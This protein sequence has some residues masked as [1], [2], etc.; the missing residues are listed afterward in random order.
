MMTQSKQC[1]KCGGK[2]KVIKDPCA[3]C[4]GAG[5]IRISKTLNVDIPAG[6]DNGQAVR[7]TGEGDVGSNGGSKG[8]LIVNVTVKKDSFFTRDGFDAHCD[9]P[10]TYTQAVLGDKITIP[11]I[12]GKVEHNIPEGTQT[13]SVFRFK[14]KG[15]KKLHRSDYGDLYV[16]VTVEVPKNLSK[17]QKQILVDFEKSLSE[18]NYAKRKSFFESIKDKL[19]GN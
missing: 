9:I 13:G 19:K 17:T 15:I 10:I 18:E 4:S 6:I 1:S 2:G 14:G 3:K 12:D 16:T 7:V 5:K 8:N 11:T